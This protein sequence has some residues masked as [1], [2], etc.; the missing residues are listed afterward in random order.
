MRIR[1]MVAPVAVWSGSA[2][3]PSSVQVRKTR[4]CVLLLTRGNGFSCAVEQFPA[5]GVWLQMQGLSRTPVMVWGGAHLNQVIPLLQ[6]TCE[7]L[8][9]AQHLAVAQGCGQVPVGCRGDPAADT[10]DDGVVPGA[11]S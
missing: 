10:E 6:L 4:S 8:F 11:R 3:E 7:H 1:P 2:E 9:I 5:A